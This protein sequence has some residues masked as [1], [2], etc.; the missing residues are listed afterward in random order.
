MV[1]SKWAGSVSFRRAARN[2]GRRID[3]LQAVTAADIQR[4]AKTWFPPERRRVVVAGDAAKFA[5]ALK[6]TAPE[7]RPIPLGSLD[8]EKGDGLSR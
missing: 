3:A 4:Y 2:L 1:C 7:L 8:L 5:D 6:K